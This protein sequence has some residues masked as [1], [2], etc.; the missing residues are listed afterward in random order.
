MLDDIILVLKSEMNP[1]HLRNM[2]IQ[3]IIQENEELRARF[4]NF[5]DLQQCADE[6]LFKLEAAKAR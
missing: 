1:L 2:Q 3:D 6:L 5:N 4:A